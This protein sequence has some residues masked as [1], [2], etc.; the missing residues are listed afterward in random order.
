MEKPYSAID[1]FSVPPR[2]LPPDK[3]GVFDIEGAEAAA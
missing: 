3:E 1:Y 2:L